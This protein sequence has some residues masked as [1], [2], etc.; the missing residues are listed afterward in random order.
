MAV[1]P[2]PSRCSTAA[3]T[4]PKLSGQHDG[5][6]GG[7]RLLAHQHDGQAPLLHG[8]EPVGAQRLADD[9]EPVDGAERHRGVE[10]GLVRV[11][12]AVQAR[13]V[14]LDRDHPVAG[15][16]RGPRATPAIRAPK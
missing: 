2:C 3:L 15:G 6:V 11:P 13:R 12:L 4:P 9:H 10:D 1:C 5:V 7:L 16:S 14:G 8:G